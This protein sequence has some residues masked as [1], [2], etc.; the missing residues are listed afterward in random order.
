MS[1]SMIL[2]VTFNGS[3]PAEHEPEVL[4]SSGGKPIGFLIK[5]EKET[6]LE[7]CFYLCIPVLLGIKIYVYWL[8][9]L[10]AT[11]RAVGRKK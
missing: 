3:S 11:N 4:V 5:I 10:R 6:Y 2:R 9:E 8:R 7:P 1:Q